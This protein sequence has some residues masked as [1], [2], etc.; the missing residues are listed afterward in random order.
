MRTTLLAIMSLWV[1]SLN[2]Q[3]ELYTVIANSGLSLRAGPGLEYERLAVVPYNNSV[4]VSYEAETFNQLDTIGD[5]LG[6]WF[7]SEVD[8]QEGFLYSAYLKRGHLFV[9]PGEDGIN[10]DYRIIMPGYRLSA[11]NYDPS[12]HW[13][14]LVGESYEEHTNFHL[15][16]VDPELQ[17]DPPTLAG[18]QETGE[19]AGLVGVDITEGEQYVALL[20]GTASPISEPGSIES[21]TYYNPTPDYSSWGMPV[22]AFQDVVLFTDQEGMA[23]ILSGQVQQSEYG[24]SNE[25]AFRY[26]QGIS[27]G[28]HAG[29]WGGNPAQD[30]SSELSIPNWQLSEMYG[31]G[32]F[33]H[34]PRL[35]W[36]GDINGDR[37]PDLIYYRPNTSECCGGSESFYLLMS[38]K[39]EGEWRW[40]K[41]A[42]DELE[43]WG[44]C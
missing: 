9:P 38:G 12:L 36:Q 41:V 21:K 4:H 1:M 35:F 42:V 16:A 43:A 32:S 10:T 29:R 17:I 28:Y 15:Q 18:M 20:I 3:M 39:E 19:L 5:Y 25:E 44:G 26:Y 7:P 8:G 24:P 23:Y 6:Y 13:Y 34:H 22:Y 31:G 2:A 14:A 27:P 30:L 40:R 33:F 11:L 37:M